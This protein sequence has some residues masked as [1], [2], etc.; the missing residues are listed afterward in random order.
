MLSFDKRISMQRSSGELLT[1][2]RSCNFRGWPKGGVSIFQKV[3]SN[4]SFSVCRISHRNIELFGWRQWEP[5]LRIAMLM[6]VFR[7]P[8]DSKHW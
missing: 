3:A 7:V 1:V 6:P 5:L 8:A 4:C 2:R